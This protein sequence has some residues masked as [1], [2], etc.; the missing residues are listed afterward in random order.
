MKLQLFNALLH[1]FLD[2]NKI[3]ILI[4]DPGNGDKSR[5]LILIQL[6]KQNYMKNGQFGLGYLLTI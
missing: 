3:K 4:I 1:L 6:K 5:L 2:L